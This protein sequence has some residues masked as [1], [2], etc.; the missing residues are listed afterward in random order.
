MKCVQLV[1]FAHIQD[2][3]HF[4]TSDSDVS[5][6]RLNRNRYEITLWKEI[7]Y[8]GCEP[9]DFYCP[10]GSTV[11]KTYE[12]KKFFKIIIESNKI[13]ENINIFQ[14]GIERRINVSEVNSKTG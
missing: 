9:I 13:L 8:G 6:V 11:L 5:V 10:Q 2:K 7:N 4:S 3:G 14:D 12:G 1:H